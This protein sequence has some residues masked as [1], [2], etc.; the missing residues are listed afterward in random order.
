MFRRD[1]NPRLVVISTTAPLAGTL[2]TSRCRRTLSSGRSSPR[3]RRMALPRQRAQYK[4]RARQPNSLLQASLDVNPLRASRHQYSSCVPQV[5]AATARSD[6]VLCGA[7]PTVATC[8]DMLDHALEQEQRSRRRT[9]RNRQFL[10]GHATL[11]SRNRS[12][13]RLTRRRRRRGNKLSGTS[14]VI[15]AYRAPMEL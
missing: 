9:A 10:R 6:D 14:S 11:G 5:I 1:A 13:D 12:H 4:E 2:A 7:R 15:E 3:A 8:D